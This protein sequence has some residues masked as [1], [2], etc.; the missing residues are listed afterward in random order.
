MYDIY[1]LEATIDARLGQVPLA[2]MDNNQLLL[3]SIQMR[4]REIR[5][6]LGDPG[7]AYA[8]T[9]RDINTDSPYDSTVWDG[10]GNVISKPASV[11]RPGRP[12]K[13]STAELL[14]LAT[15]TD[16]EVKE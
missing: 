15:D 5:L 13:N 16:I 2:E 6:G 11:R 1:E 12:K 14:K 7:N 9:G 3:V 8:G 4:L 10:D